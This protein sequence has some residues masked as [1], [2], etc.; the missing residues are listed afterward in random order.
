MDYF[1][2]LEETQVSPDYV[3]DLLDLYYKNADTIQKSIVKFLEYDPVYP[4]QP[5]LS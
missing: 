2:L 1:R 5:S 3:Q 4:T